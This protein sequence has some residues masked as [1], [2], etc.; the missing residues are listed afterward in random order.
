MKKL[1][2]LFGAIGLM[3]SSA[4]LSA[5]VV[6]C[7][8]TTTEDNSKPLTYKE[9]K[10]DSDIVELLKKEDTKIGTEGKPLQT[11]ASKL[12]SDYKDTTSEEYGGIQI[13]GT[14]ISS[15]LGTG[16]KAFIDEVNEI[17]NETG[18]LKIGQEG[19]KLV[20]YL[21]TIKGTKGE[22]KFNLAVIK[23]EMEANAET[24]KMST[25]FSKD[26]KIEVTI[27]AE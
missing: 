17:Y 25:K 4:I 18:D 3:S 1:L 13:E 14:V 23:V 6:S 27:P 9:G 12:A 21:M 7:G 19:T 26:F 2:T 10:K 11:E 8:D 16:G 20:A 24:G 22:S 5:N 15:F